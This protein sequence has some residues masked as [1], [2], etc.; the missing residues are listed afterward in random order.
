[1]NVSRNHTQLTAALLGTLLLGLCCSVSADPPAAEAGKLATLW[2][3]P[4]ADGKLTVLIAGVADP[5]VTSFSDAT[6]VKCVCLHCGLPLEYKAAEASKNCGVCGCQIT[7]A[8]C[9]AGV[10]TPAKTLTDALKLLPRGTALRVVFTDPEKP[11]SGIQTVK[12][13]LRHVLL[14]VSGLDAQTPDQLLD[15]TKPFGAKS[16]ELID[17]G[18]RLSI[19]LK[20]DWTVDRA[21]KLAKAI[22]DANGK[23]L[24]PEAPKPAQ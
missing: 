10:N 4:Q 24:A 7:N 5:V 15:L 16:A 2:G 12:V 17:S 13:D 11:E 20:T 14:P 8:A 9:T 22:A 6:T 1:M 18:K 21:N 19:T 23:V 3:A